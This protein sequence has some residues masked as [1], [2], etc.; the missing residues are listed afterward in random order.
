MNWTSIA[1]DWNQ[2]R[3]FL[4]AV[5]EGSFSAASR[6]LGQTQ[7]TVSR[8]ISALEEALGLTLFEREHSGLTPTES[9]LELLEHVRTMGEAAQRISL[10]ASG[11]SQT[12]EGHVSITA[13]E[14]F[15][16]HFLPPVLEKLRARAPRIDV[17]IIAANELRDLRKREADIA[18][19]HARPD[20][21]DL[22]ARLIG[23][24]SAHLYAS[25][26]FLERHGHPV[27]PEDAAENYDFIGFDQ[28]ARAL[29]YMHEIGLPLRLESFW[30]NSGNGLVMIE[31][32][33]RGLGIGFLTRDMARHYP[34]LEQVLP[35][36]PGIPV[37]VWLV[38]HREL[39]TSRRI[40]L[41]FDLLAEEL[42]RGYKS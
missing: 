17:D 39:R 27:S 29:P 9:A 30:L 15:A 16:A 7:P 10:A 25:R 41:V 23:E 26:D 1:F 35:D 18:I 37:P 34:D 8:Q 3:T 32:M 5:E 28:N 33:R 11:Q 21:P 22:I 6:A 31:F 42:S 38:T 19:R 24:T 36:L 13:T 20:Q 14:T 40:R 12:I 4:A 2:I